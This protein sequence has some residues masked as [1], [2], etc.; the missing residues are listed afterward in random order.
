M[1][2]SLTNI[3]LTEFILRQIPLTFLTIGLGFLFI[4]RDKKAESKIR[5]SQGKNFAWEISPILLVIALILILRR[6]FNINQNLSL[7]I[8]LFISITWACV[9]NRIPFN[10]MGRIVFDKAN[11]SMFILGVGIMVFRGVLDD[12][13]ALGGIKGDLYSY[14]I[15]SL[16]MIM[17]LPFLAGLVTGITVGFVGASFPLVISLFP[18]DPTSYI[19]YVIL[20]FGCGYLGVL[21][22]PVHI[23]LILSRDYFKVSLVKIYRELLLPLLLLFAGLIILFFLYGGV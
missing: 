20:A 2:I 9:M 10:K 16:L 15:P 17:F 12:S 14:G 19:Q 8:S 6:G 3:Q 5:L 18:G 22:S 4:L 7:L 23:C 13:Q 11:L 1:V 21:S